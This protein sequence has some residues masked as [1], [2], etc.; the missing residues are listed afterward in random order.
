MVIAATGNKGINRELWTHLKDD[1]SVACCTSA[2]DEI[3]L[4]WLKKNATMKCERDGVDSYTLSNGNCI[5]LLN[6]GNSVNFYQGRGVV[7]STLSLSLAEYHTAAV[8]MISAKEKRDLI[9]YSTIDNSPTGGVHALNP[10]I[11][12]NTASI[13]LSHFTPYVLPELL[14]TKQKVKREAP[15]YLDGLFKAMDEVEAK[16]HAELLGSFHDV[17]KGRY[18]KVAHRPEGIATSNAI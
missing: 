4:E 6:H 7:S 8:A 11:L 1:A 10:T 13:W 17:S 18:L 12:K 2:D 9:E 3:D 5:K 14:P 15:S 16:E